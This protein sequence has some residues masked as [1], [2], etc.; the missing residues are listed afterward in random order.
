MSTDKEKFTNSQR[1]H[2]DEAAVAKQ[3][4]IAKSHGKTVKDPHRMVKRKA[5]D[6]GNPKCHLCGN[7]RRFH[8]DKLTAQEKKHLQD[9]EAVRDKK[10]NGLMPD[11]E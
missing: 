3:V 2:R 5:M 11:E 10:H 1:R 8:K 9:L 7:P 6:C 4:R